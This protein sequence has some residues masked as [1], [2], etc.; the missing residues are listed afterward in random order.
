MLK[1]KQDLSNRE[2]IIDAASQLAGWGLL[3]A[4]SGNLS[5]RN[6]QAIT[7]TVSGKHKAHLTTEDFLEIDLEGKAIDSSGK[8]PSAETLLHTQLYKFFPETQAVF[9]VHSPASVIISKYLGANKELRL[10]NY[11]LLKALSGIETHAHIEVLPIFANTQNIR[12]LA[13]EVKQFLQVKSDIHAYLIEGHG[14][15]SWG[16]SAAEVVRQIEALEVLMNC[17][18]ELIK[19]NKGIH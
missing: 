7:I 10:E 11:E 13:E 1:S 9:H 17:E 12:L 5:M 8:K 19:L 2:Q 18:L 14:L 6:D 3:P 16:R 4:T 15:Y